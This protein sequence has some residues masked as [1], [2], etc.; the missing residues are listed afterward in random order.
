[1]RRLFL[2]ACVLGL[3]FR[4]DAGIPD[5]AK[6][7]TVPAPALP[8]G[9]P[10]W[11]QRTLLLETSIVVSPDGTTWR[12][13]RR[14]VIQVLSN[15]V[16][17]R[18]FGSFAFDDTTKVKKS[19]GWHV[20]PGEHAERNT[21]GAIDLTLS[22]EFLTDAKAR[23]VALEGIKRGSLLIYEFEAESHPYALTDVE[24]FYDGSPIA[25]ARYSVELP[26]GWGLKHSWLPAAG[27]APARD[28]NVFTFEQ[29]DLMPQRE[30]ALAPVPT[31]LGPRL[32]LAFVPPS[33]TTASSPAFADWSAVGGWYQQLASGR[34]AA[35]DDIKAAVEKALAQAGPAPLDRIR[36][37][38]LLVRDRVRYVA[39][40][41]GIGGYQPH[42]AADV[43]KGLYGDCKDKG[44]L[45]RAA[46]A[47]A[48]YASYPVLI[49]ATNPYTVAPDVPALGSFDHF[50]IAVAW[51]KDAAV[52]PEI[53]SGI[54]EAPPAGTLLVLDATDERAWPG[55]L[56]DNLAGKTGLLVVDGKGV[57]VT[58]PAAK[59]DWHRIMRTDT[60]TIDAGHSVAVTRVSR[61]YGG[62]AERERDRNARS[63]KDRREAAESEIR[64]AWPGAEVKDYAVTAEDKDGAFVETISLALPSGAP[65]LQENAYWL[66]PGA[67]YDIDRVP[68]TRR[69]LPVLYPYP[70]ELRRETTVKGLPDAASIPTAQKLAGDGWAVESTFGRSGGSVNGVWTA[71][72][73]RTRFEPAAFAELRQFW[74]AASKAAAPGIAL[75]P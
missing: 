9:V 27:P 19:K 54:V 53:A 49:H 14:K 66:F 12:V 31:D 36:A 17:D 22:Q 37:V 71:T 72:L 51:P 11:P 34:D 70:V 47:V 16:D 50:V 67:T 2:A 33:G 18:T 21:G 6:A 58:L 68:L 74:S 3:A 48:G 57:L 35:S 63:F 1:M 60:V 61:F 39:R 38:T 25:L 46:L 13:R 40:E 30:D 43:L 24:S 75:A 29:R 64:K 5:W 73:S 15:R 69:T 55:T 20:P 4:A 10:D 7:V 62:P 44:T 32:V 56:P 65:S 59:P 52:P 45:L 8:D 28:G 26:A 23:V 41:V 42:F